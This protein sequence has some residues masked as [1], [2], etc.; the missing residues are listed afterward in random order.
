LNISKVKR[1]SD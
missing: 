1:L